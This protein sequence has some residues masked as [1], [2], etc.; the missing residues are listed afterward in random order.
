VI[1]GFIKLLRL[2]PLLSGLRRRSMREGLLEGKSGWQAIA[3]VM[4]AISLLKRFSGPKVQILA[5]EK[6]RPGQSMSVTAVAP[7]DR[8]GGARGTAARERTQ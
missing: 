6:L 3:I 5:S 7:R 2:V 4:I 1:S 8:S